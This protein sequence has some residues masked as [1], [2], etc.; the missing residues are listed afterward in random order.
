MEHVLRQ[1]IIGRAAELPLKQEEFAQIKD[2][3]VTLSAAFALEEAYDLVL[4]NYIELEQE[5][6]SA[7]AEEACREGRGYDDFFGLRSTFN[8]R[9][10]NLLSA[11]RSYIDQVP[12][13]LTA[14]AADVESSRG[15]VK[16]VLSQS[17]D[18]SFAFRFLEAMRNHV[19]HCGLAVHYISI[20]RRRVEHHGESRL[21]I[22]IEPYAAR[23]YLE[24]DGKFKRAVLVETP[25][26]VHLMSQLRPYM[27]AFGRVQAVV[28]RCTSLRAQESRSVLQT[29]IDKY[30]AANAGA[31]IGLAAIRR[32][33]ETA[34]YEE[35]VS[36][37]LDWDDV[38]LQLVKRNTTLTG[39]SK[40]IVVS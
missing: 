19:Q 9:F 25:E 35:T 20:G 21:E 3:R 11:C 6:V 33:S 27:E 12:Q 37:L 1:V 29:N 5:V 34:P 7:A 31:V 22:S 2:A 40:R 13:L 10:V 36:L 18:T 24:Q 38:R 17:Y 26:E 14:C 4:S 30:A 28:R 23:R 16:R 32:A 8:R 39:V 15:E